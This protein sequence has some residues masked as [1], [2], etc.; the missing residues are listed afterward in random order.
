MPVAPSEPGDFR[1]TAVGVKF[2]VQ[3]FDGGLGLREDQHLPC[4]H[5]ASAQEL[6]QHLQ[7]VVVLRADTLNAR[8]D[9]AQAL[10][11]IVEVGGPIGDSEILNRVDQLRPLATLLKATLLLLLQNLQQVLGLE[12]LSRQ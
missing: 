11:V 7:L 10:V 1:V 12:G 6:P 3:V 2:T 4:L 9:A 8:Q 5:I